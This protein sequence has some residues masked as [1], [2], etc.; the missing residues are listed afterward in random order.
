VD[1][2]GADALYFDLGRG[3]GWGRGS[4]SWV[5]VWLWLEPAS[6]CPLAGRVKRGAWC[7]A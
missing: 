6:A 7:E 2:A 5:W 3:Y 4:L 1:G